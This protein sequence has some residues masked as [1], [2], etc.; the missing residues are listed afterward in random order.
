MCPRNSQARWHLVLHSVTFCIF[1]TIQPRPIDLPLFHKCLKIHP[2]VTTLMVSCPQ[3][4]CLQ[5]IY[6][7][8]LQIEILLC[9]DYFT[10][11]VRYSKVAHIRGFFSSY[12]R[13][14]C[15]QCIDRKSTRLNSSH[16]NTSRMPSS[17]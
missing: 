9:T 1:L 2:C 12:L 13:F 6:R 14:L 11:Y 15:P 4:N 17:A 5:D 10:R 8:C 16:R 3:I 7:G